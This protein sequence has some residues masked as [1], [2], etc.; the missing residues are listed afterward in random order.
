L[1]KDILKQG[2]PQL[3]Q[4]FA[5][6]VQEKESVKALI[7]S[8]VKSQFPIN[9]VSISEQRRIG[10]LVTA[11]KELGLNDAVPSQNGNQ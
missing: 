8:H 5:A 9:V 4:G 1:L 3:F 6:V 11:Y 10:A 7:A 2:D